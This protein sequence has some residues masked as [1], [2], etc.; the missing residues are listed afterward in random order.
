[1]NQNGGADYAVWDHAITASST[2]ILIISSDTD[3]WVYGLGLAEAGHLT[4]KNVYVKWGNSREFVHINM[5]VEEIAK[6]HKQNIITN[7]LSFLVALY[8]LSGC[9]YV[10]SLFGFSKDGFFKFF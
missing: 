2:S 3:T 4:V 7:P 9:D 8:I 6:H 10:S 5:E 1:M